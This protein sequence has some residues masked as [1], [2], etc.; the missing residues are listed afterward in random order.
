M[1]V[2]SKLEAYCKA[3]DKAFHSSAELMRM[4]WHNDDGTLANAK[5][6]SRRLQELQNDSVLC[7][8]YSGAKRTSE[9]RWIPLEWRARYIP[10]HAQGVNGTWKKAPSQQEIYLREAAE[11]VKQFDLV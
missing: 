4:V 7:V 9:Y 8:R 5:S 10:S 1:S 6:I 2:E 3:Y 11:A